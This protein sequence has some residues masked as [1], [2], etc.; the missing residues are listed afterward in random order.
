MSTCPISLVLIA[1]NYFLNPF[2]LP[3]FQAEETKVLRLQLELSQAK[4]ELDRR[5][6]EKEEETEAARY[7]GFPRSTTYLCPKFL[8]PPSLQTCS[9]DGALP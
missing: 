2:F 6:Q 7:L 9:D 3:S 8:R 5:L 4:G 1:F